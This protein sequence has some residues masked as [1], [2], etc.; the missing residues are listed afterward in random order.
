MAFIFGLSPHHPNY[1]KGLL[2]KFRAS[3]IGRTFNAI[4]LVLSYL[5]VLIGPFLGIYYTMR[6]SSTAESLVPGPAMECKMSFPLR[7]LPAD[8]CSRHGFRCL[9]KD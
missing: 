6:S 3:S 2:G 9:L 7:C 4:F 5:V 1:K 8:V